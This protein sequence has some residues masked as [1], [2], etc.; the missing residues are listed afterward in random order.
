MHDTF[1]NVG[2][3]FIDEKSMVGLKTFTM[4]SKRLQEARPH[5]KDKPFGNRS[6]VLLGDFQPLSPVCDSPLFIAIAVNPSGYNI[7]PLFDKAITFTDLVRQRGA[8]QTDFRSQLTSLGEGV[9]TEEVPKT[10]TGHKTATPFFA[11]LESYCIKL[12]SLITRYSV[13]INYAKEQN[14]KIS[15]RKDLQTER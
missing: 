12:A 2:I 10:A 4:V 6:V 7:Y 15:S 1:S 5:Y 14:C 3:L 11:K 8:D 9:F 13:L